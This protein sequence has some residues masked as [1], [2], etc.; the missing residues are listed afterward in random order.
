[1][2]ALQCQQG[3]EVRSGEGVKS[4]LVAERDPLGSSELLCDVVERAT[5]CLGKAKEREGEG[6]RSHGHEEQVDIPS[7]QLLCGETNA[8]GTQTQ[9]SNSITELFVCSGHDQMFMFYHVHWFHCRFQAIRTDLYIL[10]IWIYVR[11]TSTSCVYSVADRLVGRVLLQRLKGQRQ[12]LFDFTHA[13]KESFAPSHWTTYTP[14]SNGGKSSARTNFPPQFSMLVKAMAMGRPGWS[15]SSA[16]MNQ[17]MGPG[18]S[19]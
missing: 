18:P 2:F 16:A 5:F 4:S 17:E 1:M 14:T 11:F 13:N 3:V 8:T 6:G 15:N 9:T 7:A 19:S 10:N 12:F